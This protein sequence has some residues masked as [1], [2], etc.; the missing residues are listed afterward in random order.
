MNLI[1]SNKENGLRYLLLVLST[2]LSFTYAANIF[3]EEKK[4]CVNLVMDESNTTTINAKVICV[5]DDVYSMQTKQMAKL[6][7]INKSLREFNEKAPV[8][9]VVK[10]AK[11]ATVKMTGDEVVMNDKSLC[12]FNH[13]KESLCVGNKY[14]SINDGKEYSVLGF[15]LP[16]PEKPYVASVVTKRTIDG[17]IKREP[18]GYGFSALNTAKTGR[19]SSG[20]SCTEGFLPALDSG[21]KKCALKKAIVDIVQICS[22][23]TEGLGKPI[24]NVDSSD[25]T[26]DCNK[27]YSMFGTSTK[28]CYA[29]ISA[30]CTRTPSLEAS[31]K[32]FLKEVAGIT[33]PKKDEAVKVNDTSRDS[34]KENP[35][36]SGKRLPKD[37]SN[38]SK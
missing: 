15:S 7:E 5:G 32:V 24:Y 14:I 36:Q 19:V 4:D 26:Y 16:T 10:D 2:C 17:E 27:E 20:G 33:I 22:Q 12:V 25:V 13:R 31:S 35:D 34:R 18:T 30:K 1:F 3:A 28:T 9:F 21:L 37:I 8:G 6:V 38:I 29:S 23:Y 11:D